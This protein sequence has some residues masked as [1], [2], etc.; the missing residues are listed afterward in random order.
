MSENLANVVASLQQEMLALRNQVHSYQENYEDTIRVVTDVCST[1]RTTLQTSVTRQESLSRNINEVLEKL[2]SLDNSQNLLQIEVRQLAQQ[3][4]RQVHPNNLP[5]V[6]TIMPGEN[7]NPVRDEPQNPP[8]DAGTIRNRIVPAT[9][10]QAVNR[11]ARRLGMDAT[12]LLL[13][14]PRQPSLPPG[15]PESWLHL[16]EEW[17]RED[18]DSFRNSRKSEWGN[19]AIIMRYN[20]RLRGIT[21]LRRHSERARHPVTDL[22]MATRLDVER[23]NR[24]LS[25]SRHID[26]LHE[27]DNNIRRRKRKKNDDI[28]DGI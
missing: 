18:L 25:L 24:R 13:P 20:K 3:R 22:E 16:V 6:P 2:T 14:S 21:Q 7:D 4:R 10:P 19:N 15:F 8:I 1:L 17:N 9:I 12:Q 5:P 28:D 11:M 27:M 26:H 23:Q